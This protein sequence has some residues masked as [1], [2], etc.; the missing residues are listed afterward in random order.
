MLLLL[1]VRNSY[2]VDLSPV[3][4]RMS[5]SGFLVWLQK[6][7]SEDWLDRMQQSPTIPSDWEVNSFN[8]E[9]KIHKRSKQKIETNFCFLG[10]L[11]PHI[12]LFLENNTEVSLV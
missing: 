10:S 3:T 4:N 7:S 6:S 1:S 11:C 9:C 2:F 12:Y 8:L 5:L